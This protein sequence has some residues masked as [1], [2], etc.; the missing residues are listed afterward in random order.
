MLIK[1]HRI[2]CRRNA[3]H[4]RGLSLE[5][6]TPPSDL[7]KRVCA[8]N[9]LSFSTVWPTIYLCVEYSLLSVASSSIFTEISPLPPL[10]NSCSFSLE[11]QHLSYSLGRHLK[12]ALWGKSSRGGDHEVISR[13]GIKSRLVVSTRSEQELFRGTPSENQCLAFG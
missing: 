2:R 13:V 5:T 9:A 4:F 10:A 12:N 8:N 6:C 11:S 1:C 3:R 7:P